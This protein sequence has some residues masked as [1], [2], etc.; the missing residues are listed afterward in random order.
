MTTAAPHT[1]QLPPSFPFSTT[2]P[3]TTTASAQTTLPEYRCS[4]LSRLSLASQ[5]THA[6]RPHLHA[7]NAQQLGMLL[8]GLARLGARPSQAWRLAFYAASARQLRRL[9]AT[10]VTAAADDDDTDSTDDAAAQ[11][12]PQ[13]EPPT[14]GGGEQQQEQPSTADQ[15]R[16][17]VS[18]T[19][20]QKTGDSHTAAATT[21]CPSSLISSLSTM[22]WAWATLGCRPP[23]SWLH[24]NLSLCARHAH[25][26]QPHDLSILMWSLGSLSYQPPPACSSAVLDATCKLLQQQ[27]QWSLTEELGRAAA[28]LPSH[29]PQPPSSRS[30]ASTS[31]TSNSL[32]SRSSQRRHDH[33]RIPHP[34]H[35]LTVH[36]AA[37]HKI[38]LLWGLAC[39]GVS[40]PVSWMERFLDMLLREGVQGVRHREVGMLA[41]ALAKMEQNWKHQ[42]QHQ[43]QQRQKQQQEQQE[44]TSHSHPLHTHATSLN[45]L[46]SNNTLPSAPQQTR[47]LLQIA[48]LTHSPHSRQRSSLLGLHPRP[49]LRSLLPRNTLA[50]QL[51]QQH[52]QANR[53]PHTTLSTASSKQ[54]HSP[55]PSSPPH[56]SLAQQPAAAMAHREGSL[57]KK[58]QMLWHAAASR[59]GDR[60]LKQLLSL[61]INQ[62]CVGC[63]P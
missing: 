59:K 39:A 29:K 50:V 26:A 57:S 5:L 53:T 8:S 44:G 1:N 40:P 25:H 13:S 37:T 23:A 48:S 12:Q 10:A 33:R 62:V 21:P 27:Q 15:N 24:T 28:A 16:E 9:A 58:G 56:A 61:C 36:W 14:A 47:D 63:C 35:S 31:H 4:T 60:L 22:L 38:M 42:K 55:L 43:A 34:T 17:S 32:H 3:T 20:E 30:L 45:T 7:C 41:Y 2:P 49:S 51:Q 52:T 18:P 54:S 11:P 19:A 46:Q 6:S